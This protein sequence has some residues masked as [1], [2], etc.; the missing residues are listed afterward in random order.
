MSDRLLGEH[1]VAG[2]LL[3]GD[4]GHDRDGNFPRGFATNIETYRRS[5]TLKLFCLQTELAQSFAPCRCGAQRAEGPDVPGPL[6][7]GASS[8]AM[9]SIRGSWGQGDH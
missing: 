8:S 6:S 7:P 9:S 5:Q 1:V 2:F 3:S 4:F